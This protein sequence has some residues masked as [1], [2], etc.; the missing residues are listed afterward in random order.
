MRRAVAASA[1]EWHRLG[2]PGLLRGWLV[3]WRFHEGASWSDKL[4]LLMG[5]VIPTEFAVDLGV[6]E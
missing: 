2:W 6:V 4:V 5:L 1:L 3:G